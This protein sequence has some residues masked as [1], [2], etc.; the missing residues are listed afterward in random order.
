M[1]LAP[2]MGMGRRMGLAPALGLASPLVVNTDG[3][4]APA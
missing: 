3:C 2:A 4:A 1:G